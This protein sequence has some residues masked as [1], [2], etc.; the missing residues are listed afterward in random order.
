MRMW[1]AVIGRASTSESKEKLPCISATPDATADDMDPALRC[2]RALVCKRMQTATVIRD[3]QLSSTTRKGGSG[4]PPPIRDRRG[5][6]GSLLLV[7]PAII[8][9]H[10]FGDRTEAVALSIERLDG[11]L[12]AAPQQLRGSVRLHSQV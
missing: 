7:L 11:F 5:E 3:P 12:D 6:G 9:R 4:C 2:C 8:A 10:R 1:L